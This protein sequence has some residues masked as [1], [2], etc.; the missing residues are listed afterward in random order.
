MYAF[1]TVPFSIFLRFYQPWSDGNV[2]RVNKRN[3]Q[4]DRFFYNTTDARRLRGAAPRS[5]RYQLSRTILPSY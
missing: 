3:A 2:V 4:A 1:I 5:S